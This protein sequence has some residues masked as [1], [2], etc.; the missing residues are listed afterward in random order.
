MKDDLHKIEA[1]LDKLDA[2][3]DD[4]A[5]T[6]A[7]NTQSLE[8]H[9]KR[10]NMLEDYLKKVE[11]EDLKPI[12]RHVMQVTAGIR[13]IAWFC[14]LVAAIVSVLLFLAKLKIINILNVSF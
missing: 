2:R 5:I 9:I 12:K 3:L 10:T 6:L 4:I 14:S 7:K 1:K 8:V 11:E 13:G